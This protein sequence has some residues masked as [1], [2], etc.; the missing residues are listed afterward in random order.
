M[1]IEINRIVARYQAGDSAAFRQLFDGLTRMRNAWLAKA[2]GQYLDDAASRQET[3]DDTLWESANS[4]DERRANGDFIGYFSGNLRRANVDMIRRRQ[5]KSLRL[6]V[7][8]DP[9]EDGVT[10][11]IDIIADANP[12]TED[13]VQKKT[14]HRQVIRSLLTHDDEIFM[15][16]RMKHE[17]NGAL[18]K[19]L[20]VHHTTVKRK[21]DKIAA[22]YDANRFGPI[23]QLLA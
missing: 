17:T 5:R 19:A 16:S 4:F 21:L 20:G 10:T 1:N 18:A 12:L 6:E 9:L 3:F 2:S 11:L 8:D 7:P 22:R 23:S 15:N 13:I 14:D